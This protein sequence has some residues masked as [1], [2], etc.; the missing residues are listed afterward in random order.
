MQLDGLLVLSH[1]LLVNNTLSSFQYLGGSTTCEQFGCMV[2]ET[3]DVSDGPIPPS[4]KYTSTNLFSGKAYGTSAG[5]LTRV[6]SFSLLSVVIVHD[7]WSNQPILLFKVI[8]QSSKRA[9]LRVYEVT[10]SL[11]SVNFDV[12]PS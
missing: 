10:D 2:I 12:N 3:H 4:E 1:T 6:S 8:M 5:A 9:C 11:G 7:V